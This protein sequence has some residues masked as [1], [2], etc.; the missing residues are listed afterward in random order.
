MINK[1]KTY[2]S[3]TTTTPQ[4]ALPKRVWYSIILCL[5]KK[6]DNVRF[7]LGRNMTNF[8]LHFFN[9]SHLRA[10]ND[11]RVGSALEACLSILTKEENDKFF[12]AFFNFSNLVDEWLKTIIELSLSPNC[13]PWNFPHHVHINAYFEFFLVIS[14]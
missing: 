4:D 3:K 5:I 7:S 8:L 14:L 12:V 9:F 1:G 13:L 10:V 2:E 11:W 6:I